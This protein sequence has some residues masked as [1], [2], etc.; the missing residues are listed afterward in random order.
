MNVENQDQQI[1]EVENVVTLI[2]LKRKHGDSSME[3]LIKYP[4]TITHLQSIGYDISEIERG[5][6]TKIIIGW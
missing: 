5:Y 4:N 3:I 2:S 1:K 6:V